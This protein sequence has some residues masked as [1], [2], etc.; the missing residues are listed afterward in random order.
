VARFPSCAFAGLAKA[1]ID[2]LKT[3]TAL[4][5]PT[6]APAASAGKTGDFDGKWDVIVKCENARGGALGYGRALVATVTNGVLHAEDPNPARPMLQLDGDIPPSGKTVLAAHGVT[7]DAAYTIGNYKP[8]TPYSYN[9]DA[10]FEK[11]RG[12]G[13]RIELRRCD[14]TFAKR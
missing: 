11:T 1:R 5:V 12:T 3:K 13:K 4:T 9:V 14:L 6:D 2:A 7:G 8:G 10:Q